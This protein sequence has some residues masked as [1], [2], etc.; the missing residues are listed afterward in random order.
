MT[1]DAAK[2]QFASNPT[3]TIFDIKRLIGRGFSDREVQAD[4]KHFPFRVS[5]G[6]GNKP[7][8]EVN[9]D[10]SPKTFSPEEISA[11][12]LTKMKDIAE[13]YLGQK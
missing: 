9:V 7:V 3:N 12:V 10:G 5:T 1:G 11:M 4:I 6:P 2:N 8:V 13:G